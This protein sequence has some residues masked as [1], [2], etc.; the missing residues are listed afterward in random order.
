MNPDLIINS[1]TEFKLNNVLLARFYEANKDNKLTQL[2][3]N[4]LGYV[5]LIITQTKLFTILEVKLSHE[6]NNNNG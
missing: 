3:V 4:G 2:N 5:D 1:P 6:K